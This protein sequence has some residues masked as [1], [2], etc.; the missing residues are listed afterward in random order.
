MNNSRTRQPIHTDVDTTDDRSSMRMPSSARRYASSGVQTAMPTAIVKVTDHR[1]QPYLR[2]SRQ[3]AVMQPSVLQSAPQDK[4]RRHWKAYLTGGLF[5]MV[6]G[7]FLISLLVSWVSVTLDDMRYGRPRTYQTEADVG[8]G[9]MSH[10]TVENI[11]GH[12][13]IIEIVLG[14]PKQSH[15]LT[16]PQL[17]GAGAD[18]FPVTITFKDVKND[19]HPE[20]I[21]VVNGQQ[22]ETFTNTKDGFTPQ[23]T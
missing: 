12:I 16:G 11:N 5:V 23:N 6:V 22:M 2:A 15:L 4:P 21:V 9:G 10:F 7:W 13:Y 1:G 18:L 8:H 3:Q 20:M 17:A 19:G 14:D